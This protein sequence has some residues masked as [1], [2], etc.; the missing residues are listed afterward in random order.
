MTLILECTLLPWPKKLRHSR[1][2]G[3]AQAC[4]LSSMHAPMF[5]LRGCLNFF[6]QGSSS[7]TFSVQ[8]SCPQNRT[9][10]SKFYRPPQSNQFEGFVLSFNSFERPDFLPCVIRARC[11]SEV[12]SSMIQWVYNSFTTMPAESILL[13]TR[14]NYSPAQQIE[15]CWRC[16]LRNC[17]ISISALIVLLDFKWYLKSHSIGGEMA[18]ILLPV[19][20]RHWLFWPGTCITVLNPSISFKAQALDLFRKCFPSLKKRFNDLDDHP[21]VFHVFVCRKGLDKCPELAEETPSFASEWEAKKKPC[22]TNFI[23]TSRNLLEHELPK[24]NIS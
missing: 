12:K 24:M 23:A 3:V 18:E 9:I 11:P 13:F 17:H 2:R 4:D 5:G 15:V 22:H 19:T 7:H 10:A 6:G 20:F 21:L 14:K 8:V 16:V 1:A